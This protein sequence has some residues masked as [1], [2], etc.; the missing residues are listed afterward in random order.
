MADDEVDLNPTSTKPDAAKKRTCP[1]ETAPESG[2]LEVLV[3][4]VILKTGGDTLT[5][6]RIG[7][8]FKLPDGQNLVSDSVAES[9]FI[10]AGVV[11][12]LV[13]NCF[14]LKADDTIDKIVSGDGEITEYSFVGDRNADYNVGSVIN[15]L[16]N[17]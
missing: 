5:K 14:A 3:F 4:P 1:S 6:S 13:V 12:G 8:L 7:R 15:V 10:S 2:D 9:S 17:L 16:K 11:H